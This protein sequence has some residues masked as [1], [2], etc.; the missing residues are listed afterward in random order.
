MRHAKFRGSA[1]AAAALMI[2][3]TMS[4][5]ADAA[6]VLAPPQP[7]R[8]ANPGGIPDHFVGLSIEWSLIEQYM[9]PNAQPTFANL[10]ANL[11]T[12]VLRIGG[13]SQD[14]TP[15]DPAAPN[16]NRVITPEDLTAIRSTLDRVNGGSDP[17][18]TPKWGVVLGTALAPATT[19]RPWIGPVHAKSFTTQGVQPAFAGAEDYVAGIELGNEPDLTY[20]SD[21]APYLARFR[22]YADADVTGPFMPITPATSEPISPWQAIA[23]RSVPTRFFWN[24]GEVLDS[25]AGASRDAE[26]PLGAWAADH[27]Y[28]LARTC[29][30]DQYRCPTI[31]RLLSEERVDNFAYQVYT[32]ATE[33]ARHGLG[34]RM[35]EFNTAAGRGAPGVSDVAAS[36]VWA[37]DAM[38]QAACPQTPDQP[39]VN[40]ECRTGAVGVNFH[41]AEVRAF[42][43]PEE[44]N[45]Y[46]NAIK[47][48]PSPEAGAPTAA[49]EYYA[50]LLFAQLAQG[51]NRV[52]PLDLSEFAPADSHISGWQVDQRDNHRLF[53]MNKDSG[54]VTLTVPAPGARYTVN[55]MT[56]YDPTGAARTLDA[57]SVRIDGQQVAADG[58]WPGFQ[59]TTELTHAGQLTVQLAPGET[60]VLT[61]QS[62]G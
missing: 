19:T 50:L 46:Y 56:P 38:F 39:G 21:V 54:P 52:R 61:R 32:H 1:A 48:D 20:R 2:F 8:P 22:E 28:P 6:D 36:A 35:E 30:N 23:D 49:P 59:P 58:T 51:S 11:G 41:N 27:F 3:A 17:G 34:Y 62:E 5:P 7:S 60:V 55:R 16:T 4:A 37:L 26:G 42:Y 10:L 40:A 18:R 13:S 57:P 33:A 24:W 12:G 9:G 44:G 53:L 47:F 45:G 25:T 31:E 15:F 14:Q 29:T 43:F